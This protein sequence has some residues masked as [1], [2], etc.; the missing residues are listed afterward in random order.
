MVDEYQAR[1]LEASHAQELANIGF[2]TRS[3]GVLR[4]PKANGIHPLPDI[5]VEVEDLFDQV[6]FSICA[7][8]PAIDCEGIAAALAQVNAPD[9]SWERIGRFAHIAQTAVNSRL[10]WLQER[11]FLVAADGKAA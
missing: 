2:T 10:N 4:R 9:A 6:V 11:G 3:D 8:R 7:R 5:A 1:A